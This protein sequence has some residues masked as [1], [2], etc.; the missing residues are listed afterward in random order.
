VT[1]TFTDADDFSDLD[2][3]KVEAQAGPL[4]GSRGTRSAGTRTTGTRVTRQQKKL[5]TLQKRLATEMF[6]AGAMIGMG[7]H[8]TGYYISQEADNFTGAIV[9]LASKRPEWIEALEHIADVGPGLTAGRT[10]LGIGAAFAVD[11]G[12]ADPEKQ[13]MKFLGVTSAWMSVQGDG[14]GTANGVSSYVPPPGG[15]YVPVS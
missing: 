1:A 5:E 2:S 11:R 3:G 7:L 8:V 15:R 9:E 14:K 6:T 13:F 10:V 4:T 12:R